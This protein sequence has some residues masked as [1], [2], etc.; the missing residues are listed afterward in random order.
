[1]IEDRLRETFDR[2]AAGGP[3]EAGAF[4]RFLRHRRT[5]RTRR[6]AGATALGLVV[7]LALV[8]M[9]PYGPWADDAGGRRPALGQAS[10]A[11]WRPGPLV[12]AA[13]LQ[14]FEIEVPSGWEASRTPTGFELRPVTDDLRRQ[15]P[16]PIQVDTYVLGPLDHPQGAELF[17]D[18][19][20]FG[21]DIS[22]T[23]R[24]SDA[25]T[26]GSF[27]DG[28]RWLR[29]DGGT[30]DRRTT[31][32]YTPWPYRCQGGE[33]CADV[34]SLRTLR[35]AVVGAGDR[36]WGE[37]M[38]L[39]SAL[40]RS[41]RPITNAV[42]GRAHAP[43]PDC[44]DAMTARPSLSFSSS[45]L[46]GRS[47]TVRIVWSFSTSSQLIPCH[48]RRALKLAFLD[49]GEPIELEGD[50]ERVLEG[51]LPEGMPLA[52]GQLGVEWRWTNWCGGNVQLRVGGALPGNLAPPPGVLLTPSARPD[53]VDP[54]KPSRL[55][56]V[57][58]GE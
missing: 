6:V 49:D 57:E 26:M 15:L 24:R 52:P 25:R 18:N 20:D 40:L 30:A 39:A 38:D 10:A 31:F 56:A 51:D 37:A 32:W 44:V 5:H 50:G 47:P 11:N 16:T 19:N 14:G 43:R 13:P 23:I 3:G 48:F 21:G 4:D 22:G 1:M 7:V 41:A 29:T 35:V 42:A 54:A 28:R 27:P 9:L 55:R 58:W 45:Q 36:V 53:C 17:Q 33:P 46:P 12:T 2:V 34:L 8:A